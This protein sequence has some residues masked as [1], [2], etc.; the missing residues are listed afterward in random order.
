MK[1]FIRSETAGGLLFLLLGAGLWLAT[2]TQVATAET[3][4]VT[5]RTFPLLV[6][7]VLMLC[8]AAL[9]AQG[10]LAARRAAPSGG[11]AAKPA[12][13]LRPAVFCALLLACAAL[14]NLVGMFAAVLVLGNGCVAFYRVRK[15]SYYVVVNAVIVL[16]YLVFRFVFKLDLP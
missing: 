16:A 5:A 4:A 15:P 12:R 1:R 2:P 8:S 7:G 9:L 11:E 6:I 13:Y 10:L 3:A 14:V